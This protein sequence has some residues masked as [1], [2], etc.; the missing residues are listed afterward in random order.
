MVTNLKYFLVVIIDFVILIADPELK[1]NVSLHSV[2]GQ[3]M[4]GYCCNSN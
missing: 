1:K 2:A 4:H 3:E